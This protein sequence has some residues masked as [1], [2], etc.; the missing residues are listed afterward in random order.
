MIRMSIHNRKHAA[1]TGEL[2]DTGWYRTFEQASRGRRVKQP[3]TTQVSPDDGPNGITG[4]VTGNES[5]PR[6]YH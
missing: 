3:R 2:S 5:D 6:K 4:R 1:P